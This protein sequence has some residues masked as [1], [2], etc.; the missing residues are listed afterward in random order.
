MT[1]NNLWVTGVVV[2]YPGGV[3]MALLYWVGEWGDSWV[4][5]C[6]M[7]DLNTW[8]GGCVDCKIVGWVGGQVK[9][10]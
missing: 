10:G 4:G 8:V 7:G 5:K 1:M 6:V 2:F 3:I 9:R